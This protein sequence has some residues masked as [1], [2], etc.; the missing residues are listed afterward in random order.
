MTQAVVNE[1]AHPAP[2]RAASGPRAGA[3]ARS[4]LLHLYPA[5]PVSYP[6]PSDAP[7]P[8]AG[9][10]ARSMMLHLYP[11]RSGSPAPAA[12]SIEEAAYA[13]SP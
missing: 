10:I 12:D 6:A 2:A 7:R 1:R 5:P 3:L 9:A 13:D 4:L 11:P 8:R